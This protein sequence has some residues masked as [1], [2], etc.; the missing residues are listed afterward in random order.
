MKV[1]FE[2]DGI[3][4]TARLSGELDHYGAGRVREALDAKIE[5]SQPKEFV[6][7]LANIDFMDSS[8]LGLVLGRYKLMNSIGGKMTVINAP[9][10]VRRVLELAGI[11][12]LMTVN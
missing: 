7:D 11:Q 5:L 6:L 8:G 9:R 2:Y 1:V 4:L 12:R 3:K 10:P